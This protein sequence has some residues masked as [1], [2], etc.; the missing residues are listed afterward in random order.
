MAIKPTLSKS[1]TGHGDGHFRPDI[2][3]MTADEAVGAV[4]GAKPNPDVLTDEYREAREQ[5]DN[6]DR[7]RP[8]L[9]GQGPSECST[10]MVMELFPS[11]CADVNRYYHDLGVHWSATRHELRAAY[12]AKNGPE[13]VRLTYILK[14]LLD[15]EVREHYD[16]I[17]IGKFLHDDYI[18][19]AIRN[20]KIAETANLRAEGFY[21][22]ADA[23]EEERRKEEVVDSK[24]PSWEDRVEHALDT[25]W[26]WSYYLLRTEDRDVERMARWQELLVRA[27]WKKGVI[28]KI[29][30]GLH[31]GTEPV[32]V[33]KV[34]TRTVVFLNSEMDPTEDLALR[35]T[36]LIE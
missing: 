9:V 6:V 30:V 2:V 7:N 26:G 11:F 31:S 4:I 34:G 25:L 16:Q 22:A 8:V 28:T 35:A 33:Q 10:C 27:L 29:S 5:Y 1:H 20:A 24:N 14:Q 32:E 18:E 13:S 36:W 19:T 15:P 23:I 3:V 12:I 17:P 21:E